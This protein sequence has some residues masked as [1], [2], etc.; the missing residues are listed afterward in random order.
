MAHIKVKILADSIT[1]QGD[2]RGT[3][4][5]LEYWRAFHGEMLTHRVFSRSASSSRAIP[6]TTMIRNVWDNPAAPTYWGS[7][8]AG[9]QAGTELTGFKLWA[10]KKVWGLAAKAACMFAKGLSKLGVHKQ[11]ANRLL[12]P[13]QYIQ[14]VVTSTQ[15]DNFFEL[16]DHPDA[17][18]E[19]RDLARS[20]HFMLKNN[21]PTVL[22]SGEWHL[23]YVLPAERRIHQMVSLLKFS[24]ARCA[25]VSY[26]RH[27]GG[28][29]LPE[30][31]IALHD[32]LVVS[33]P[34]HASPSE[35]QFMFDGTGISF[36]NEMDLQGNLR[37]EG[38]V[39]YR[40]LLEHP[41]AKRYY[42]GSEK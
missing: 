15:W 19:F 31:D 33:E 41:I 37:G 10:S 12:E 22:R 8:K 32:D 23:P 35:H 6:V 2:I 36:D 34:R 9:M 13:F 18:P 17:F 38:I 28:M 26:N 39:Q 21:K 42:L 30:K 25:R 14:V 11:I 40:K 29:P 7:N 5:Q 3:T 24:T 16:R 4:F 27:D 1:P 20:M